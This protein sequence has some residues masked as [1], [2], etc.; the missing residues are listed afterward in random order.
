MAAVHSV[1]DAVA[2]VA[3]HGLGHGGLDAPLGLD[4]DEAGIADAQAPAESG[5]FF[6]HGCFTCSA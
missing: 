1:D 6:F 3:A 2:Q 4:L 5:D